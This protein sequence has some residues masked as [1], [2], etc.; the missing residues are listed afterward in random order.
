MKV[1]S[2]L[3]QLSFCLLISNAFAQSGGVGGGFSGSAVTTRYWDCCKPSCS[4]PGK[5]P[6]SGVKT[7]DRNNNPLADQLTVSGCEGG[8]AFACLDQTPI[9]VNENLALGFA[10]TNVNGKPEE[11]L[12]GRCFEL[13]FTSGPV[14]GKR[15]IVQ[16]TNIGF[17]LEN[18][19]FDIAIPGGGVGIFDGCTSQFGSFDGGAQ[20]GGVSSEAE[21]ENLPNRQMVEGCKFRF[22]F[23]AGADNPDVDFRPVQCPAELVSRTGVQQ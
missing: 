4:W 16:A 6:G 17:D 20:Y 7:C 18:N 2:V 19:H 22:G 3:N 1:L 5:G 12:C 11:E 21:C 15:M 14:V 13:A 23:L 10:A 8:E 9:V